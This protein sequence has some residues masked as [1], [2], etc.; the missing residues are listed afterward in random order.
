MLKNI[1]KVLAIV[2]GHFKGKLFLLMFL[3][4]IV[5][6]LELFSIG[7]IPVT[8]SFVFKPET[9]NDHASLSNIVDRLGVERTKL[10]LFYLT[11]IILLVVF[12]VK[13]LYRAY[14]DYFSLQVIR[15]I[16]QDVSIK[17]Y[18]KYLKMPYE[19]FLKKSQS[20][21][22]RNLKIE[23]SLF[24]NQ[25]LQSYVLVFVNLATGVVF[26]IFLLMVNLKLTLIIA[27]A[28]LFFVT[29]YVFMLKNKM[30]AYSKIQ[31]Q[32]RQTQLK[33]LAESVYNLKFIKVNKKEN[34][35]VRLYNQTLIR[36]LNIVKKTGFFGKLPNSYFEMVSILLILCII[37]FVIYNNY[38]TEEG[39][40]IIAFFT[41]S[42]VRLRSSFVQVMVNS[43]KIS[44]N[45][46]TV[47]PIMADLE[48]NVD[49]SLNQSHLYDKDFVFK[50]LEVCDLS[51][52]YDKRYVLQHV[53]LRIECGEKVLI[54]GLSGSGKTTLIDL[55]LG[56]LVCQ[57]GQI[58]INNSLVENFNN[59]LHIVGYVPQDTALIEGSLKEN[60]AFGV[61]KRR[62]DDDKVKVSLEKAQLGE[63]I[64]TLG[65]EGNVAEGGISLSGGQKQRIGI[66]RSLYKGASVLILDEPT[67][68]LDQLNESNF[69]K[70]ILGLSEDMTVICISHSQQFRTQFD[71][72]IELDKGQVIYDSLKPV[73]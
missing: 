37:G 25:V 72:V 64:E 36:F 45:I 34:F 44:A 24:A 42:I 65:L 33:L 71:R 19:F 46:A 73:L 6:L 8:F 32:E 28:L 31:Q 39:I 26:I 35:I 67:S 60:V 68:S 10:D 30:V 63:L 9:I 41:L 56:L 54:T 66:A 55:I 59:F 12:F 29:V 61:K 38:S 27:S 16:Q 57:Q 53:D 5:A 51:Y 58:Y 3:L 22:I 23:V 15:D 4:L 50:S 20:E 11:S 13:N 48:I 17:L 21:I 14:V 49:K 43:N 70:F 1:K 2:S 40:T 69:L 47:D 18:E 52:G 7:V 62:I